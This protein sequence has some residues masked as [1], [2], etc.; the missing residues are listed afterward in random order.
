MGALAGVLV[1]AKLLEQRKRAPHLLAEI[2]EQ[3][4]VAV[5]NAGEIDAYSAAYQHLEAVGAYLGDFQ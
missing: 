2:L 1:K 5:Q 4:R 3:N